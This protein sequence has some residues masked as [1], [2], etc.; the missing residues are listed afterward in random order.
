MSELEKLSFSVYTRYKSLAEAITA[1]SGNKSV[2]ILEVGGRGNFLKKFLPKH[3]ITILDVIDS[4]EDNYVKGDGRKLPFKAGEFDI[5]VSTDVLEHIPEADRKKFIEE[6]IRVSKLGI[7]LAFPS[8]D[9]KVVNIE[10]EVNLLYRSLAGQ[11]HPWL[12]EHLSYILP[13]KEFVEKILDSNKLNWTCWGNQ[14]IKLWQQM[15]VIDIL[16]ASIGTESILK[17]F[18]EISTYYNKNIQPFDGNKD[19]YRKIFV[20]TKKGVEIAKINRPELLNISAEK[21][22]ELEAL[23]NG[24]MQESTVQLNLQNSELRERIVSQWKLENEITKAYETIDYLN[25]QIHQ[26]VS[27]KL[28]RILLKIR[29]TKNKLKR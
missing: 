7:I 19:G 17:N 23:I 8:Y 26:I 20:A 29:E 21:L 18:D 13:K 4:D 1:I 2:K 3:K 22:L 5:V 27:S 14:D 9:E 11:D 15:L 25:D 12:T 28:Y 6:Q 10:K 16:V 24:F